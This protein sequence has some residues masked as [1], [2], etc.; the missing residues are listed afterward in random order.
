MNTEYTKNDYNTMKDWMN[1][2]KWNML[3]YKGHAENITVEITLVN[4]LV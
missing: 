2:N 1:E 3:F 4:N